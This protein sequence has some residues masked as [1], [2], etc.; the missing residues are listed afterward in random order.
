MMELTHQMNNRMEKP[1]K[2]KVKK[3][4]ARRVRAKKEKAKKEKAKKVM[5]VA[6]V[7]MMETILVHLMK[8]KS[9]METVIAKIVNKA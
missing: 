9:A 8:L 5:V 6:V 4:K 1:R 7:E 2:A 3:A